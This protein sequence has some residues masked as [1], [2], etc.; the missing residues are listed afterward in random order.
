MAH[1]E[2]VRGRVLGLD[3]GE[4]WIGVAVSDDDRR[5][6]LPLLTI[7]RRA[8]EDDGARVIAQRLDAESATL[9]VVGVPLNKEGEEDAQARS[10]RRLGERLAA[11]LGLPVVVVSERF[12][13]P[14]PPAAPPPQRRRRGRTTVAQHQKRRVK[15]HAL[16]AA[17]ILQR[18][19]DQEAS[20]SR[21]G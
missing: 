10:F 9:V 15:E 4:R 7:D 18:W 1:A 8:E 6:A 21:R 16:A 5:L 14:L 2:S 13:N 11:A 17:S 20:A 3:P 19:L 12:T